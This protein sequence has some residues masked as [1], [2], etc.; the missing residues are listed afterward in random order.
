MTSKDKIEVNVWS[1]IACPWCYVAENIFKKSLNIFKEKYKDNKVDIIFHAYMIDPQT[2]IE[3]EEYLSYNKRRWGS[4]AWTEQLREIG[5][6]YE[7]NFKNWKIWPNTLL[8][9]KLMEEGKKIGKANEIL[10]ELFKYCYEL[11]KNVS[12]ESTLNE[13]AK[14]YNINNWNNDENLN[15]VKKDEII[16]KKKYGIRA[17]PYFIFPNDEV[18]EGA[19]SPNTF[20]NALI[21]S[22][23]S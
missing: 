20:L 12:L 21:Q 7:A 8:C 23:N 22:I 16:G 2:K 19:S 11:G 14:K 6:K 18:V 10:D 13:I 17:V 9:H 5:K 15:L 4:D 1:D 3:G